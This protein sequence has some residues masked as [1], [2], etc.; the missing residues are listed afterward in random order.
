MSVITAIRRGSSGLINA[1]VLLIILL[2]VFIVPAATAAP[3][4]LLSKIVIPSAEEAP[5]TTIPLELESFATS[6]ALPGILVANFKYHPLLGYSPT[7]L[8]SQN[9]GVSWQPVQTT[10]WEGHSKV[11][12]APRGDSNAPV[13]LLA[14]VSS[15]D[16]AKVGVYRTGGYGKGWTFIPF[17]FLHPECTYGGFSEFVASPAGPKRLYLVNYCEQDI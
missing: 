2:I 6:A 7:P 12:V 14:A 16:S 8:Y 5:Q 15:T 13:R 4:E 17:G 1:S 11:A 3:K 10:P 9:G